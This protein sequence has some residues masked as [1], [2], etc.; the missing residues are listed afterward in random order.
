M[1][2]EWTGSCWLPPRDWWA[3]VAPAV[4]LVTMLVILAASSIIYWLLERRWTQHRGWIELSEWA[5]RNGY[6]LRGRSKATL[7]S[8][9]VDLLPGATPL[10]TLSRRSVQIVKLELVTQQT[11][12][13][14]ISFFDSL[15]AWPIRGDWPAT[16]L[17][18]RR[19][20]R[21]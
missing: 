15:L 9:V 2:G 5:D 16:A 18:R 4:A 10:M 19:E 21:A 12:G 6:R 7:P 8:V 17:A 11:T 1:I 13:E 20:S 3:I 14:R